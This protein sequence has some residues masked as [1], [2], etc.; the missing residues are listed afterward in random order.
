MT[1]V[2][3][4]SARP[5]RKVQ[6]ST[7]GAGL[8]TVLSIIL[9]SWASDFAKVCLSGQSFCLGFLGDPAVAA[10]IGG[11]LTVILTLTFGYYFKERNVNTPT[12]RSKEEKEG[13]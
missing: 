11:F 2:R 5:T 1:L 12:G 6:A 8:G 9:Q 13:N 10:T 7:M 4:S 3:Q